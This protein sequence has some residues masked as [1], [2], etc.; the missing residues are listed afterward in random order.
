MKVDETILAVLKKAFDF[1]IPIMNPRPP[2][3]EGL[4][5]DGKTGAKKSIF[6][7]DVLHYSAIRYRIPS[8]VSSQTNL[9]GEF[10]TTH[11]WGDEWWQEKC[12]HH[13]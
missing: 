8:P 12:D 5:K 2:V 1:E 6:D 4:L 3:G 10:K 9:N 11:Q 7:L 13:L